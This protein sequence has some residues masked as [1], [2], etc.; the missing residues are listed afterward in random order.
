MQ[1]DRQDI[2][3]KLGINHAIYANIEIKRKTLYYIR[4]IAKDEAELDRYEGYPGD[5]TR[6]TCY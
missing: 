2:L 3:G 1:N 6:K 4:I 5:M